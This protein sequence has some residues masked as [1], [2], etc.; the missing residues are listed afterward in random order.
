MMLEPKDIALRLGLAFAAGLVFGIDRERRGHAAGLRTTLLV[1]LGAALAMLTADVAIGLDPGR[2]AQGILAGMGF[3]GAGAII[4]EGTNV[5]GLTTAALLWFVT[6]LG[7]CFGSG[8][9]Q[10]GLAGSVVAWFILAV[11]PFLENLLLHANAYGALS[12]RVGRDGPADEA[13]RQRLVDRHHLRL[14]GIEVQNDV[15]AGV[16]DIRYEVQ[17]N[18]QRAARLADEVVADLAAQ[19]G[20]LRVTWGFS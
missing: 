10:V 6:I 15:I 9:W 8:H 7:L 3:L 1:C 17:Y 19:P 2:L 20:V 11:F 5:R 12:V 13:L 16:R 14:N 4:R 18:K